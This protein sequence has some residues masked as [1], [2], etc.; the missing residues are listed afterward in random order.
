M[1]FFSTGAASFL[2]RFAQSSDG[3]CHCRLEVSSV[4]NHEFH[5]SSTLRFV[6]SKLPHN[7]LL[8]NNFQ[9]HSQ[10]FTSVCQN[11]LCL[12]LSRY[13]GEERGIQAYYKPSSSPSVH[14]FLVAGELDRPLD[15]L[16]STI[17]QLSKSYTYNQ[18]V[19][20]V[21]TRPLDDSTQLGELTSHFCLICIYTVL[22]W[23]PQIIIIFFCF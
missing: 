22:T 5:K 12:F 8:D 3:Q 9:L 6:H 16:W 4:P 23:F 18:S 20:S 15:N 21:W 13:Q 1:F 10:I 11:A 17:C 7:L 14:G 2:W 19:R